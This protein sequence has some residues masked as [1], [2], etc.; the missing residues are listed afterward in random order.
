MT[1]KE[2]I[3]ADM[4]TAMREKDT[5]RLETIRLLR[6][7]IQRKEIDEKLDL[8]DRMV[9]QIVQK[10]VKQFADSAEQ[11]TRGDRTDLAEKEQHGINVLESYLPE[12]LS[13]SETA[14]MIEQAIDALSAQSMQD[15]GKV[16]KYIRERAEGRADMGRI[17]AQIKSRLS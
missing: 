1:L 11:F 5:P 15:M 16:M 12:P 4:K 6:A 13:E 9:I 2:Q 17:S 7:A 8:D 10:L 3:V 14:E